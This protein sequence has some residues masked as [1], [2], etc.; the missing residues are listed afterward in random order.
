MF[1]GDTIRND[2]GKIKE[3]PQNFSFDSEEARKSIGKIVSFDFDVLLC[4]HGEPLTVGAS[5]KVKSFLESLM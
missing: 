1:A 3:S 5:E 4:G 2:N